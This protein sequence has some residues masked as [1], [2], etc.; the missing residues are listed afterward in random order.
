[1]SHK[2][3]FICRWN[4]QFDSSVLEEQYWTSSLPR[5]TRRF[6]FGLG[7]LMLLALILAVYFPAMETPHWVAF[8]CKKIC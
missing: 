8:L 3:F 5:V 1:M 2:T 6:Q 7:Y 4:P